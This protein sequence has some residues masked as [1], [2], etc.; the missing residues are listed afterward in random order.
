MADCTNL[1]LIASAQCRAQTLSRYPLTSLPAYTALPPCAQTI[2]SYNILSQ[3]YCLVAALDEDA[4]AEY[5]ACLCSSNFAALT[6]L[7]EDGA[8]PSCSPTSVATSALRAVAEGWCEEAAGGFVVARATPGS[9]STRAFARPTGTSTRRTAEGRTEWWDMSSTATETET[10]SATRYAPTYTG[11]GWTRNTHNNGVSGSAGFAM[12][13]GFIVLFVFVGIG[14]L[15]G[16][17]VI[18]M[19]VRSRLEGRRVERYAASGIAAAEGGQ[20][21]GQVLVPQTAKWGN[22]NQLQSNMAVPAQAQAE[23]STAQAQSS[24]AQAGSST[25]PQ[26]DADIIEFYQPRRS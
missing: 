20:G 19:V 3:P 1:D 14:V 2:A 11:D 5:A 10:G 17:A 25:A 23:S 21:G 16:V 24:T 13:T 8:I 6:S 7:I 12:T 4:D 15:I 26:R 9:T 18:A 22:E